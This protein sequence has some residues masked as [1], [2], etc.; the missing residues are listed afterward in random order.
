M[1]TT[2]SETAALEAHDRS[3]LSETEAKSRLHQYGFNEIPEAQGS[4]ARGI[5]KRLWGP[6]P[7]MLEIALILEVLLGKVNEPLLIGL[8]L[9]FS[10]GV[11]GVQER[12]AQ[13]VLDLLRSKLK[14]TASARRDGTWRVI[15]AREL[16]PGDEIHLGPGDLVPADCTVA[17]GTA[18]VDQSALTGESALVARS[19]GEI[20]Y[21]ASTVRS[22]QVTA[23]VAVTG[24]KSYF[25]RTAELVRSAR[26]SGHLDQLL[27]AVVRR[28]V[29]IDAVLAALL[30]VFA[31]WGSSQKTEN[32][33]R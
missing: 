30:V 12:R 17:E 24:A 16:V 19:V 22:G 4:L 8:W 27:F 6:I 21:S 31:L 14:V 20:I 29:A 10:A 28:L 5:L 9:L 7:W 32:K 15:P 11:G 18:E 3:G 26:S 33:A 25:G 1:T 13:G 23:I 2:A